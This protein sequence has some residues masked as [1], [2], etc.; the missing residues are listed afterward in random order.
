MEGCNLHQQKENDNLDGERQRRLS[1]NWR[2][3]EIVPDEDRI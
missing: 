2:K 3:L 1:N